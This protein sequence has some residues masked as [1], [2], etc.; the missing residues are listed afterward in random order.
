MCF[1][2]PAVQDLIWDL[3]ATLT[4]Y[5]LFYN[6]CIFW[7]RK[8]F[9][10][11]GCFLCATL[12]LVLVMNNIKLVFGDLH[13]QFASLLVCWRAI[14]LLLHS[15]STAN[16][17]CFTLFMSTFQ[18]V[19]KVFFRPHFTVKLLFC[20]TAVE[21]CFLKA[22]LVIKKEHF[23]ARNYIQR[24]V[25]CSFYVLWEGG[26]YFPTTKIMNAEQFNS[27][28]SILRCQ[29][30]LNA[31]SLPLSSKWQKNYRHDGLPTVSQVA[32][33]L[34]SLHMIFIHYWYELM[35]VFLK[36]R[37]LA[38]VLRGVPELQSNGV[39]DN[40]FVLFLFSLRS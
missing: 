21:K 13:W 2:P 30:E 20:G 35:P 1:S 22:S 38:S 12:S 33:F 19:V 32:F 25:P 9:C 17:T 18:C 31:C 27:Q 36:V 15:P 7:R 26:G 39:T 37:K 23:C 3:W 8:D 16:C 5:I 11:V 14:W 4:F 40:F 28:P 10:R 34:K 6:V 24:F 29:N